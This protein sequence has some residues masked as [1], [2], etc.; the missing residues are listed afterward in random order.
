MGDSRQTGVR[1]SLFIIGIVPRRKSEFFIHLQFACYTFFMQSLKKILKS[2]L[3]WILSIGFLIALAYAFYF[4]VPLAVDARGYDKIGWNLAQGLGYRESLEVSPLNDVG[5][6]RVGPGY[7][8]FLA[9][10]YKIFG[11]SYPAVWVIQSLLLMLTGLGAYLLSREVFRDIWKPLMGYVAAGFVVFS[12]DLITVNA[13]LLTETLGIFL[14]VFGVY[15]SFKYV[16]QNTLRYLLLGTAV[17]FLATLARTPAAFLFIPFFGYLLW[18]KRFKEIFIAGLCIVVLGTPWTVRNYQTYGAFMPFH[19]GGP[20]NIA[21]GNRP[22]AT[23]EQDPHPILTEYLEK[24]GA[25]EAGKLAKKEGFDFIRSHPLE[26]VRLTAKRTI[27]YFSAARPT[28]FWFHL[29][30]LSKALTL[31]LS[32]LYAF[33]LFVL[34]LMG[35]AS[36]RRAEKADRF[37]GKLF[38]ALTAMMP[39]AVV[40]LV[41]ETRYRFLI[42]PFLAVFAGYATHELWGKQTRAFRNLLTSAGIVA[43]VGGIDV[44]SNWSRILERI[45]DL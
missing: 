23:G 41:V 43:L 38:L 14:T 30:G 12:P 19:A 27:I 25:I 5:I 40:G 17:L 7:Q 15:F 36:L 44:I 20:Y 16:N 42:Y 3:F 32:A 2:P 11:H 18:K 24:Y 1:S 4:K 45:K 13:M 6:V 29:H 28:G 31:V 33:L 35:I 34:A 10:I 26:F 37:R 21:I 22:G 8:F 9:G 39:L